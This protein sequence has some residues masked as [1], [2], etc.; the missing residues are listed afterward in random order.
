MK[1]AFL[2]IRTK[3]TA[4]NVDDFIDGLKKYSAHEMIEVHPNKMGFF[5][6]DLD[7]FDAICF[8]YT[9]IHFPMRIWKP[10][11]SDFRRGLGSFKGPKIAFVQ[12]EQRALNDRLYFF[13]QIKLNHLMSVSPT[14]NLDLLYP[15]QKRFFN[16]SSI[17]TAYVRMD[18]I[19][20]DL[21]INNRRSI[22]LF[23]RGRRLP[24]WFDEKSQQK[25][26]ISKALEENLKE[27][28]VKRNLSSSEIF[29]VYG[30]IWQTLLY[31]SKSSVLT[32]SGSGIIDRDGRF[33]EDW[34]KPDLPQMTIEEPML[35]DNYVL[36]PRIFEYAAW[37]TLILSTSKIPLPNL[38]DGKDYLLL[39]PNLSNLNEVLRTI[40]NRDERLEITHSARKKLIVSGDF[41]YQHLARSYD[42]ILSHY[43]TGVKDLN[44]DFLLDSDCTIDRASKLPQS[45]IMATLVT[46]VPTKF[47]NLGIALL[48]IIRRA[49]LAIH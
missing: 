16:V 1:I 49:W 18:H 20:P 4:S 31:N 29:R 8:H 46:I 44:S 37:G 38:L 9:T 5:D 7:S 26:T 10:F 47:L 12:D 21:S 25:H 41:S 28:N 30:R 42:L 39:D 6:F 11:S 15:P 48:N 22:D 24:D 3:L 14:Q 33:L 19:Q 27:T 13:N 40:G 32:P 43:S 17:L 34:V 36:S 45:R 2:T 23:F 35:V